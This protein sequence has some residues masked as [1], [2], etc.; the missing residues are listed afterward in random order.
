[1]TNYIYSKRKKHAIKFY[2]I[3]FC[4]YVYILLFV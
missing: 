3:A 4:N 1:M 2:L